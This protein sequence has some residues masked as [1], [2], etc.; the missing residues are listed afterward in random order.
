MTVPRG[1]ILVRACDCR[2]DVMRAVVG[3]KGGVGTGM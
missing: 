3:Y 1:E 2:I